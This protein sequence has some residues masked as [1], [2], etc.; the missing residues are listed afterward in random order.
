LVNNTT[1]FGFGLNVQGADAGLHGA[2]LPGTGGNGVEGTSD[3]AS[4]VL[5]ISNSG[6]GVSAGASGGLP[7]LFA[8]NFN[9][10][11]GVA[12]EGLN[13]APNWVAI[14]GHHEATSFGYGV[15]GEAPIGVGVLGRGSASGVKGSTDSASGSGV[16]AENTAGG[17]ALTVTGKASFSR[18]GVVTIPAG[19]ISFTQAGVPLSSSSFILATMQ[20]KAAPFV[21]SA[22]PNPAANSFTIYLNRT[23][24]VGGVKVAYFIGD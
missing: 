22:V 21:K 4:G 3:S 5:G 14:W 12:I 8:Q 11:Q 18:S 2:N 17:K 9:T 6:Y 16:S 23:A 24:P 1:G 15:L 20:T 7:A 13:K 10:G 19:A